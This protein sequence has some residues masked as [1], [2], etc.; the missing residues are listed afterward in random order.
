[1]KLTYFPY[2]LYFKRPFKI[3]HGI[4]STTPIVITK[5]EYYISI[6]D[7]SE[8]VIIAFDGVAPVAKLEQQ[9]GRRYKSWYQTTI[10]NNIFLR[11]K[12][13]LSNNCYF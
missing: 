2:T 5:I 10:S 4:R 3:A 8:T 13:D 6:I 1:M 7:P 9:R 11:G 12:G